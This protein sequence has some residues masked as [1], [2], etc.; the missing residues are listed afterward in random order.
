MLRPMRLLPLATLLVLSACCD[1]STAP[2]PCPSREDDGRLS[3]ADT[4]CHWPHR[5]DP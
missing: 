5:S 2:T 4:A 3:R 1:G